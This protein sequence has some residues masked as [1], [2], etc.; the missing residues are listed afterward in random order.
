MQ[1]PWIYQQSGA[2]AQGRGE[3]Y[4][5]AE[6]TGVVKS[7]VFVVHANDMNHRV[8]RNSNLDLGALIPKHVADELLHGPLRPHEAQPQQSWP[9]R[10]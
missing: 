4:M 2:C 9:G 6:I 3:G 5:S 1:I 8:G 10:G 7:E